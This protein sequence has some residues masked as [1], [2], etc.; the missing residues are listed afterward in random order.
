MNICG[1]TCAVIY[2]ILLFI[3]NDVIK[4]IIYFKKIN[5]KQKKQKKPFMVLLEISW[6]S[7]TGGLL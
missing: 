5:K 6:Y 1:Q 2:I 7:I 3:F 4:Y